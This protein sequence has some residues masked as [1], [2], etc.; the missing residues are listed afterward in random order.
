LGYSVAKQAPNG[1]IH[2]VTTMNHPALHFEMNEAWILK[3]EDTG[4]VSSST[5]FSRGSTSSNGS[6]DLLL[7]E[8]KYAGGAIKAR[9]SGWKDPDGR[10]LL[11]GQ[12]TYFYDNSR[13]QWEVH[14]TDG[15][16]LGIESLWDREGRKVWSWEHQDNGMSLWTQFWPNGQKKHE[17]TW[18][19][20][21]CEG[22]AKHWDNRGNQTGQFEFRDGTLAGEA[23]VWKYPAE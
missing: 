5:S 14:F 1:V 16:K 9:W 19:E 21:R 20:G 17:S 11:H 6:A 13:K 8:E 18:R 2:L 3:K 15:R 7:S 23:G 10:Y 4:T 22:V 12:Q